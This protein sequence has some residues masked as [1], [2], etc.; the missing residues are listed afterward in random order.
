MST[1]ELLA[2]TITVCAQIDRRL[3]NRPGTAWRGLWFWLWPPPQHPDPDV[4][5]NL[6]TDAVE[7]LHTINHPKETPP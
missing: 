1:A 2:D 6:H 3:G 5:R 4:L 7:F